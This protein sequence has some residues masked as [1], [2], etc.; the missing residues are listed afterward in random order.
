MFFKKYLTKGQS[1]MR[2][3]GPISGKFKGLEGHFPSACVLNRNTAL[4]FEINSIFVGKRIW[5]EISA[6]IQYIRQFFFKSV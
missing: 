2:N 6:A 5:N 3:Q 1:L 4:R